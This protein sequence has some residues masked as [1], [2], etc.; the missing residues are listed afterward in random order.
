MAIYVEKF[1][2]YI[3]DNPNIE[4]KRCDGT[5]FSYD[6]VN[7]ASMTN[8]SQTLQI[9]GG[10]GNFPLAIL[11]TTKTLEFTFESSEF[12]LDMFAMANGVV[13]E[14]VDSK[15]VLTSK[16]YE[17][18][19]GLVLNIYEDID[20]DTIFINGFEQGETLAAGKYTVT[21]GEG[22]NA[23]KFV[24]TFNAGDVTVG[25]TIRVAY[26]KKVAAS[27]VSVLTNGTTAKGELTATWP[28]Y[29]SGVDCT[30]AS[31]KSYLHIYIPRCRVTTLPGISSS[32]KQAATQSLAF[33]ALDPHRADMHMFEVIWEEA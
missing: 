8:N 4:F 18:E 11:D 12:T 10:Q 21:A 33:T 6:E 9:T 13:A 32:Y 7:T 28:V 16:R 3:A 5:V 30:E 27:V 24:V 23:P 26:D 19:T 22:E 2:G 15:S 20:K 25:Q 17:V 1:G 29:S 31:V 14:Q